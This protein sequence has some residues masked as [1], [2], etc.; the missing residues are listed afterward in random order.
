MWLAFPNHDLPIRCCMSGSPVPPPFVLLCASSST[1]C[2]AANFQGIIAI[3]LAC[4]A[5]AAYGDMSNVPV[6][7]VHN[8]SCVKDLSCQCHVSSAITRNMQPHTKLS[9]PESPRAFQDGA[10]AKLWAITHNRSVHI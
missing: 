1:C 7:F 2:S 3:N 9:C 5:F 4:A 8:V 10:C 6:D